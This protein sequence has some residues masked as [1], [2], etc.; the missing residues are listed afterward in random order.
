MPTLLPAILTKD[1]D[2]VREKIRLL[3]SIPEIT[4]VHIDFE[5]GRFV[6]NETVLPGDLLGLETRLKIDAH[7]MVDNPVT[8]FYDLGQIRAT[9]VD[10]H[11]ESF[12]TIAE[13]M[14]AIGNL[15]A[16][17][18]QS[19][20]VLNPETDLA[21]FDHLIP[22][23]EIM[24]LMSVHPGFQGRPFLP[25]CLDRMQALRKKF[26]HTTLQIDGGISQK[27]IEAVRAY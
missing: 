19:A 11:F 21:I 27:N 8:H 6:P 26:P 22:P 17:G 20:V 25:Q 9:T 10:L 13:L 2:E 7:M 14:T 18:F 15:K 3:E 4:E 5:D 12:P 16:L 24:F 1:P 23:P